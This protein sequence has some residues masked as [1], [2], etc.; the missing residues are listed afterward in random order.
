MENMSSSPSLPSSKSSPSSKAS[1]EQELYRLGHKKR[2]RVRNRELKQLAVYEIL[3]RLPP[4]HEL[5][6]DPSAVIDDKSIENEREI[7]STS[8]DSII[9][10]K[11]KTEK[12]EQTLADLYRPI[13]N[14]EEVL[15]HSES[16]SNSN[17]KS[18]NH[19]PFWKTVPSV[20]N[21]RLAVL[22]GQGNISDQHELGTD[23]HNR[24]RYRRK[25]Q[26]KKDRQ[27]ITQSEFET[28]WKQHG[29]RITTT[30]TVRTTMMTAKRIETVTTR[31]NVS[32]DSTIAAAVDVEGVSLLSNDRGQRKAWQVENFV[33]IL[34]A[35]LSPY[36]SSSTTD[37][38]ADTNSNDNNNNDDGKF[39]ITVVDFGCGSGK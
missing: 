26:Y 25:L 7:A 21:P 29:K 8:S 3:D 18:Q 14:I 24:E 4:F 36:R 19:H 38:D 20:C 1:S 15:S 28:L 9:S 34:Y 35:R 12:K 30:P 13:P 33:S 10:K 32:S 2:Q 22:S 39:D 37:N 23:I 17:L 5:P 27:E 31:H 11:K 16:N 6:L